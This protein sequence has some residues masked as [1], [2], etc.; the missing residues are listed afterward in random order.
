MLPIQDEGKWGFIHETGRWLITPRYQSVRPDE[1]GG[2]LGMVNGQEAAAPFCDY[3]DR[4]GRCL[5]RYETAFA[6]PFQWGWAAVLI[7][8]RFQIIDRSFQP[9]FK[10]HAG[11]LPL[12]MGQELLVIQADY[13]TPK[14]G[15]WGACSRQGNVVIP[16]EYDYLELGD[17]APFDSEEPVQRVIAAKQGL[18]GALDP[19]GREVI[20][21]RYEQLRGFRENRAFYRKNGLWGVLD[22]EGQELSEAL[23]PDEA[24]WGAFSEPELSFYQGFAVVF[25]G[26]KAGFANRQG[27]L[28]LD[29]IYDDALAFRE[30]RSA[31]CREG[32]W[33][34]IDENFAWVVPP[35]FEAAGSYAQGAAPV[36]R[37][38]RWGFIRSDGS[39]LVMPKYEQVQSFQDGYAM[40]SSAGRKGYVDL[41]GH[42]I[43][44]AAEGM[45][46]NL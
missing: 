29:F 41:K 45:A 5:Q 17:S 2:W 12:D 13:T 46:G 14:D 35:G 30:G 1:G 7:R 44:P 19:K 25:S 33:G 18:F 40:I 36:C 24:M 43:F 42:E 9:L 16:F 15:V 32:Q 10:L 31:V 20:P 34:Y 3:L 23:F 39:W 26:G 37:D 6:R 28:A 11:M 38:G 21:C 4:E 8:D 22:E 27:R